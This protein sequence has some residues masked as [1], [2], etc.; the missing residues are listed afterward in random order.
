MYRGSR[1]KNRNRSCK[2]R[3]TLKLTENYSERLKMLAEKRSLVFRSKKILKLIFRLTK[4]VKSR[5]SAISVYFRL[6]V[7]LIYF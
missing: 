2:S 6:S 3:E 7:P 5:F 1:G 4:G